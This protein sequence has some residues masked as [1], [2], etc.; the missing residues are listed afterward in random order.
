M[1]KVILLLGF[2][3]SFVSAFSQQGGITVSKPQA[4]QQ[5]I[6]G[7]SYTTHT[8]PDSSKCVKCIVYNTDSSNYAFSTGHGW[9]YFNHGG[10]SGTTTLPFGSITGNPL[11]NVALANQFGLKVNY[12]DTS[13]ILAP[14]ARSANVVKYTDTSGILGAYARS[15]NVVKY[16]DTPGILAPY[17]RS[18]NFT[19][20][21]I[22]L[23]NLLNS[24]QVV[25]KGGFDS[26]L[27]TTFAALPAANV[28]P[29]IAYLTDSNYFVYNNRT[30]Y[31]KIGG[32]GGG[33]GSGTTDSTVFLTRFRASVTYVP[34]TLFTQHAIDSLIGFAPYNGATNPLG[35]ITGNQS[36]SFSPSG[37]DISGTASGPTSLTPALVINANAVTYAKLQQNAPKSIVGN[38]GVATAN[39]KALFPKSGI[40]FDS[41][42]LKADTALLATVTSLS[43]QGFL[44]TETDPVALAKLVTLTQGSGI[45]VVGT[46]GQALSSGPAWTLKADTAL[47]ST[48]TNVSRMIAASAL[49]VSRIAPIDSLSRVPNGAQIIGTTLVT[50]TGNTSQPG[51]ISVAQSLELDSLYTGKIKSKIILGHPGVGIWGG[52]SS[53]LGDSLYIKNWQFAS[54]LLGVTQSDSSVKISPDFTVLVGI[55]NTQ[56]IPNKTFT[57]PII[58]VGSDATG[59]TYFRNSSGL[60]NRLPAGTAR[61]TLHIVGGLPAWVDT[62]AGGGGS[63]T[64]RQVLTAFGDSLGLSG[65]NTIFVANANHSTPGFIS[66]ASQAKI[67]STVFAANS[68]HGKPIFRAPYTMDSLIARGISVTAHGVMSSIYT[69]TNDSISYDITLPP[70]VNNGWVL[71]TIAGVTQWYLDST[72]ISFLQFGGV[73]DNSTDNT[74]AWN[75]FVNYLVT[76][77]KKGYIPKGNYKFNGNSD[78]AIVN[79]K[80]GS[81]SIEGEGAGSKLIVT[82]KTAKL[83]DVINSPLDGVY[84]KKLYFQSTH[85][86][87]N[88]GNNALLFQGFNPTR[89]R[90]VNITENTFDGFTE[91]ITF[92]GVVGMNIIF[93]KFIS[94]LGHDNGTTTSV[95]NTNIHGRYDS[96][97]NMNKDVTIAFND[98]DGWS[99]SAATR[100]STPMDNFVYL[101]AS[102]T[103]IVSNNKIRNFGQELI[104]IQANTNVID[105]GSMLIEG[106]NLDA[107]IKPG[108]VNLN[109]AVKHTVNYGIRADGLNI[110]IINN[111]INHATIGIEQVATS[112]T[113]LVPRSFVIRGNHINF[114]TDTGY[115]NPQYG[116]Y[117][118][119]FSGTLRAKGLVIANNDFTADSVTLKGNIAAIAPVFQDSAVISNN[120]MTVHKATKNA[121][122]VYNILASTDSSLWLANNSGIGV[123]VDYSPTSVTLS[124]IQPA[125]NGAI[126][127]GQVTIKDGTQSNGFVLTTD[128]NGNAH[129]QAIAGTGTVTKDSVGNLAPFFTANTTNPTTTPVTIFTAAPACAGCVLVN[130]TGS[131]A[132]PTYSQ[133]LLTGA[134]FAGQGTAVTLYHGNAS[135]NGSFGPV[136]LVTDVT[137]ILGGANFPAL[138]GPVTTVAGGLATSITNG[139][140]TNAMIAANTIDVTTKLTG[141][142]SPA[143]GFTGVNNGTSTITLNGGNLIFAGGFAATFTTTG[144]TSVTL[145]TSGTLL[146]NN[147]NGSAL[148]GIVGTLNGTENEII[149]TPNGGNVYTASTPQGIAPANSPTFTGINFTGLGAGAGTDNILSIAGNSVRSTPISAFITASI[150]NAFTGWQSINSTGT[151]AITKSNVNFTNSTG[152][153]V[154]LQTPTAIDGQT[155]DVDFGN[156]LNFSAVTLTL[157]TSAGNGMVYTA[158]GPGATS[159]SFG[160]LQAGTHIHGNHV[161]VSG[162][163]TDFWYISKY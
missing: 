95:P 59:D 124:N 11:S 131:P 52:Y 74:S 73:G 27:V 3:V 127:N 81:L 118:Q 93:N 97:G 89:I 1:K 129:W 70:S 96:V 18:V 33:G 135:G 152:I 71:S 132:V 61:Q 4:F 31:T 151:D 7:G 15:A 78:I 112:Y 24:K 9:V 134:V 23:G 113:N 76:N 130:L 121:H 57:S 69:G 155:F 34:L 29:T 16:T 87:T 8:L 145:P 77:N 105:S 119:G 72:Y 13:N 79:G 94:P 104:A 63:Q 117:A 146:A 38:S 45:L 99:S 75:T 12:T 102:G 157:T 55:A 50:Q 36:V 60:F 122:T 140:I 83:I 42:S 128:N 114:A 139:A 5:W 92:T 20:L 49:G 160:V 149:I 39:N 154:T 110:S 85:D 141:I 41:D 44:K 109:T 6:S 14:Y 161:G 22:G 66:S 163:G 90:N 2:L 123:D 156:T 35:F 84:I 53:V 101:Q 46:P 80:S 88:A 137:G 67:D 32:A 26:A 62:T 37:G 136:S 17:F 40:I 143:N 21:A 68:G 144:L 116:V 19:P 43:R 103:S 162:S 111:T 150:P 82:S 64:I 106:N 159:I 65:G 100:L 142:G 98:A 91:D 56:T 133:L 107:A 148:S 158:T 115:S 147:G 120:T 51:Y 125:Y 108:S 126:F 28:G 30:S 54:G 48:I 58:N 10:G 153:T 47:V 138:T 86:T 25:N